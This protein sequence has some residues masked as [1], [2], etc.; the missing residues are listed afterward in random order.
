[1]LWEHGQI[2]TCEWICQGLLEILF[3]PGLQYFYKAQRADSGIDTKNVL[4]NTTGNRD[5]NGDIPCKFMCSMFTLR[6]DPVVYC[7][8]AHCCSV[9]AQRGDLESTACRARALPPAQRRPP[10]HPRVLLR[11]VG[12]TCLWGKDRC[13]LQIQRADCRMCPTCTAA[14][15]A[16]R[17][18]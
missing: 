7:F 18:G 6:M 14:A 13:P 17:E 1:M 4:R 15:H 11:R 16:W 3:R 2:S 9:L 10:G 5:L 8:W 12:R